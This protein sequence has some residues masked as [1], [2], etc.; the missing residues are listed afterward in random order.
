MD[1]TLRT[2]TSRPAPLESSPALLAKG[3]L[4]RLAAERLEPTP[5]NY[6]RC[7]R[8]E[9][10]DN[11]V[12][13][14]LPPRALKLVEMLAQRAF[15]GDVAELMHAVT[16]GHW[17]R[18]ER[19]MDQASMQ[20]GDTLA[21]LIERIVR[22]LE[23][24]GQNWTSA[25]RKVGIQRVLDANR[26]NARHLQTRLA[27]LCSNWEGDIPAGTVAT[28]ETTAIGEPAAVERSANSPA[29]STHE[30]SAGESVKASVGAWARA[31]DILAKALQQALPDLDGANLVLSRQLTD[32]LARVDAEGASVTAV[33]ALEGVC[34]DVERVLQ[35]RHHLFEQLNKLTAELT[36]SLT[37]VA[38]N[39]S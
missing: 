25:R 18:A 4:R 5:E 29:P 34:H 3:A 23:R 22:G 38:E 14:G 37:D 19:L 30:P 1:T 28:V 7:Y 31:G 9:A 24:G 35:H 2:P 17:D 13:A 10:G 32:A 26:G 11:R 6:A 33:D 21:V 15:D 39:D 16:E 20:S 36:A 27:Q 8:Q 12:S